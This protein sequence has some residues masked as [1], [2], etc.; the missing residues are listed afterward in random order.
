MASLEIVSGGDTNP[1][2]VLNGHNCDFMSLVIHRK[3]LRGGRAN[4][5][6]RHPGR[7]DSPKGKAGPFPARLSLQFERCL[8]AITQDCGNLMTFDINTVVF[9]IARI[10]IFQAAQNMVTRIFNT[11]A[12]TVAVQLIGIR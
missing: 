2:P 3:N 9:A 8:E 4:E 10:A 1:I 7:N 11:S 6:V 12:Q 5:D